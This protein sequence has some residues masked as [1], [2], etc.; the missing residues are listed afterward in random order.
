M[1]VFDNFPYTNNHELNLD[2]MIERTER[3]L[4]ASDEIAANTEIA[5]EAAEN[6]AESA[7]IAQALAD[8]YLIPESY[9][10][11]GYPYG[12]DMSDPI[13][14]SLAFQTMLNEA[15]YG[16]PIFIPAKTYFIRNLQIPN[17]VT[18]TGTGKNSVLK[19]H[20]DAFSND[21]MLLESAGSYGHCMINN[22]VLDGNKTNI[23]VVCN[24]VINNDNNAYAKYHGY[25]NNVIIRNFTGSGLYYS[26]NT[27]E[28]TFDKCVFTNNN[29]YGAYFN[30]LMDSRMSNCS[31]SA[32]GN[33]GLYLKGSTIKMVNSKCF[34]NG[35]YNQ[36]CG[37]HLEGI[38][39]TISNTEIQENYNNGMECA[40]MYGSYINII[41]DNNNHR[42]NVDGSQLQ[43]SNSKN[44][45]LN[46]V[47]SGGYMRQNTE[48]I[49]EKN[50]LKEIGYSNTNNT[51]NI[52]VNNQQ[53]YTDNISN[54]MKLI[55]T[56]YE[57]LSN[58]YNLNNDNWFNEYVKQADFNTNNTIIG[59]ATSST[60]TILDGG[61]SVKCNGLST[62]VAANGVAIRVRIEDIF[63]AAE[64]QEIKAG[65]ILYCEGYSKNADN[66]NAYWFIQEVVDGSYTSLT[67]VSQPKTN[68]NEYNK[69][70][71]IYKFPLGYNDAVNT[72][73]LQIGM[74]FQTPTAL[75]SGTPLEVFIKKC[76]FKIQHL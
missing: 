71:A 48:P 39:H 40:N 67:A 63:T 18:I 11:V 8:K 35:T 31:F 24:G 68:A 54:T 27:M 22:I 42:D 73:T 76:K 25:F 13:D 14:S 45:M 1:A 7:A 17:R 37:L 51:Y 28:Y 57:Q 60:A 70:I 44:N 53:Y 66:L 34:M 56:E 26:V 4:K 58:T 52:I 72:F 15:E 46:L 50:G 23:N 2:W 30:N 9:G 47:I 43:V 36:G 29:S 32:N 33:T 12:S 41:A 38:H 59:Y 10:A 65:D 21:Y 74:N 61:D 19:L 16:K 62:S 20:P 55:K 6:A 64:I 3:V 5:Q 75:T 69:N 49:V